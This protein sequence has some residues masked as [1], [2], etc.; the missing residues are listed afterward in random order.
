MIFF[1]KTDSPS[2]RSCWAGRFCTLCTAALIKNGA[3]QE[4]DRSICRSLRHAQEKQIEDLLYIKEYY[5]EI[6]EQ[7]ER[8][9]FQ[10]N[11]IRS[12]LSMPTSRNN[13]TSPHEVQGVLPA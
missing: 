10:A 3:V 8:M 5:P 11:D 7:M 4:P 2:C 6:L 12:A 13:K 9:Y 1:E